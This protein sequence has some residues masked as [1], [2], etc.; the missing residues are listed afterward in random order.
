VLKGFAVFDY[1][2]LGGGGR[3]GDKATRNTLSVG[4]LPLVMCLYSIP[5]PSHD[6]LSNIGL[7]ACRLSFGISTIFLVLILH[8]YMVP[9]FRDIFHRLLLSWHFWLL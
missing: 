4:P 9:H 1:I 6:L 2:Y 3:R 7:C 5:G 8:L